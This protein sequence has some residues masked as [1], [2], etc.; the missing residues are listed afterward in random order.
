[1]TSVQVRDAKLSAIN[2]YDFKDGRVIQIRLIDRNNL[3]GGIEKGTNVWKMLDNKV[4]SV[5][6]ADLQAALDDQESQ[7]SK[8]WMSHFADLEVG[9]AKKGK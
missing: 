3:K 1:M 2:V 7:I 5:T 8:I 6:T 4:Y 9:K